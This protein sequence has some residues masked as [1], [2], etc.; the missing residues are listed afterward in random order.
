M[1]SDDETPQTKPVKVKKAANETQL[2][3]LRKGM[4]AMKLKRMQTSKTEAPPPIVIPTPVPVLAPAPAPAPAPVVKEKKPR[5]PAL[6]RADLDE[7]KSSI[8]TSLKP[9]EVI[10][11][12][13]VERVVDR[14]VE[15]VVERE[16]LVSGS[17]LLNAIFFGK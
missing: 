7:F 17:A 2:A 15:K 8:M 9:S 4:E 13:P 12:V 16:R 14:V 5:K 3:N 10:K 1:S 6:S 11:E